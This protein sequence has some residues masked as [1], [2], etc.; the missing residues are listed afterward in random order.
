MQKI[1]AWFGQVTTGHGMMVL[2]PTLLMALTG[3]MS[4]PSAIPLLFAGAIGLVW[5][6]N[7]PLQ[8]DAQAFATDVGKVLVKTAAMI[9]LALVMIG[10]LVAC[11]TSGPALQKAASTPPGQLFCSIQTSGG[12]AFL[13]SLIDAEA[14]VLIPSLAP[15]AVLAT[16]ATKAAVDADCAQA[17]QNV[18][19]VS[20]NPVS[21][22]A[23]GT[24]PQ[25][26]AVV[27]PQSP[28]AAKGAN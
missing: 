20:G 12:E 9:V 13:A 15:I 8:A 18:N 28:T 22:P 3:Q 27:A 23:S 26:I 21:P 5:P 17:A 7:K 24:V 14:N 25:Q 2:A 6:E 19:G 16:G 4:W 10:V 1:T 11:G